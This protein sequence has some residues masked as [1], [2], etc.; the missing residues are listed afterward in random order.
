MQ[1]CISHLLK[2]V[3]ARNRGGRGR[4]E[5]SASLALEPL[6]VPPSRGRGAKKREGELRQ[7]TRGGRAE[8][9]RSGES[10]EVEEASLRRRCRTSSSTTTSDPPPLRH[11]LLLPLLRL[12]IKG[13]RGTARPPPLADEERAGDEPCTWRRLTARP[14][15]RCGLL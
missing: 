1:N 2:R 5:T 6:D 8:F 7:L 15:S 13:D 9:R 11:H 4:A 3:R 14:C 12:H 10:T